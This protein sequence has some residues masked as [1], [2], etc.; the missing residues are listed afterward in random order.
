[1]PVE[2]KII[3]LTVD[4][5]KDYQVC[6]RF[7]DYK[8]NDKEFEYFTGREIMSD[9][10]ENTLKRVA[11]FFFY[12]KQAEIVPSYNALLNRWEKLWFPKDMDAYD[13]AVEQMDPV[14]G[15]LS[16]YSNQAAAAL[17]QFHNVFSKDKSDPILIDEPY[18][19]TLS[20]KSRLE[21]R[22]DVMLKDKIKTRVI[23]WSGRKIKNNYSILDFTAMRMAIE[24][25][26]VRP[27][28]LEFGVY[29]LATVKG[30]YE[31][32]DITNSDEDSLRYWVN[33]IETKE[34]YVPRRGLTPYCKGCAFDK[35]CSEWSGW[36]RE[37]R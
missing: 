23:K 30:K 33:E 36:P 12:K 28:N 18:T 5:I 1:M 22:I 7:Y 37:V 10:F 14:H 16:T 31:Q 2:E 8:Y 34:V 13:L 27:K 17:E 35:Q 26:E 21:G 24:N 25:R 9:R 11:S 15:N 4:A 29:D 3:T 19:L 32:F 6:E 20:R